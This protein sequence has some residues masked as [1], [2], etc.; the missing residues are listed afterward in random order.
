MRRGSVWIAS[1]KGTFAGKPR[2]VVIV[3]SDGFDNTASVTICPVTTAQAVAG[4]IRIRVD[5]GADTGLLKDCRIMVDKI[6]TISRSS[7]DRQ[8]GTLSDQDLRA[9][10]RSLLSFLALG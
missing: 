8:V 1:G 9:L 2:P 7:L 10:D 5:P 3:Q 6:T 4:G